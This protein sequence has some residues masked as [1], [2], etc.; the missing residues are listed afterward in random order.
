LRQTEFRIDLRTAQGQRIVAVEGIPNGS[1]ML[2]VDRAL[3]SLKRAG[4]RA[5]QVQGRIS[6]GAAASRFLGPKG[7]IPHR[8]TY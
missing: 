6:S 5:A 1:C 3:Q 7:W 2:G 4:G 8:N